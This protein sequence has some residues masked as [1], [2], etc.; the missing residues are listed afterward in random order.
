M[1]K[2]TFT[3]LR[4]P[5]AYHDLKEGTTIDRCKNCRFFNGEETNENGEIT[6]IDCLRGDIPALRCHVTAF[7]MGDYLYTAR[8][9]DKKID[10]PIDGDD[11]YDYCQ[12]CCFAK[13]LSNGNGICL[14]RCGAGDDIER[15]MCYEGEIWTKQKIEYVDNE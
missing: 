8:D 9:Y 11:P 2:E 7:T 10:G 1:K 12:K 13:T 6:T 4:V 15:F 5:C 3:S 14:L